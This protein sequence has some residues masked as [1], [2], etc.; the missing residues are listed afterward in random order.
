VDIP[1]FTVIPVEGMTS[2]ESKF[3]GDPNRI[4]YLYIA[5]QR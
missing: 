5:Q 4:H 2:F 1:A 3:L